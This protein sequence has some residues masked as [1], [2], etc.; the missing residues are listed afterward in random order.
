MIELASWIT[1]IATG[2]LVVG[3]GLTWKTAQGT[4]KHAREDSTRRTRPYVYVVLVPGLWGSGT[5]DLRIHNAGQSAAREL[6]AKLSGW[7]EKDDLISTG[8]RQLFG[9]AQILPPGVSYRVLWRTTLGTDETATGDLTD[10]VNGIPGKATVTFNYRGE[11]PAEAPYTDTYVLDPDMVGPI[12]PEAAGGPKPKNEL[13]LVD[14]ERHKM[15]QRIV[16]ALGELRR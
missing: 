2:L 8:L 5:W 7:P 12:T 9:E 13:D 11:D 16:A 15:M 3:A 14:A 1:A 10:R 4:L 6:T